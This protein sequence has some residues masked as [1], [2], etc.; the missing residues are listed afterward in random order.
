MSVSESITTKFALGDLRNPKVL[1][2]INGNS[3]FYLPPKEQLRLSKQVA[4]D[5]GLLTPSSPT[6]TKAIIPT[7]VYPANKW[8]IAEG[9]AVGPYSESDLAAVGALKKQ[10][11]APHFDLLKASSAMKCS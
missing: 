10:E 5:L 3:S 1:E 4:L 11:I 2:K 6:E 8:A 7:S 9:P